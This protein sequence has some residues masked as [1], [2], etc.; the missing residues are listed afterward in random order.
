MRI[1]ADLEIIRIMDWTENKLSYSAPQPSSG[2]GGANQANRAIRPRPVMF[3]D[4]WK[5]GCD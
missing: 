5:L 4:G 3:D 2:F 1:P